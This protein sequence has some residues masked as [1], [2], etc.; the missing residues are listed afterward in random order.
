MKH[1]DSS[2]NNKGVQFMPQMKSDYVI[3][4]NSYIELGR[5]ISKLHKDFCKNMTKR[6]TP[7]EFGILTRNKY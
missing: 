7:I 1:L 3:T 5:I 4:Q 6:K 2:F